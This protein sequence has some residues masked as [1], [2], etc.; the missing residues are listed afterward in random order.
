MKINNSYIYSSIE[1]VSI[2]NNFTV[3][4]YLAVN[5]Y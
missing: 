1:V 3:Y 5:L 4:L 2:D